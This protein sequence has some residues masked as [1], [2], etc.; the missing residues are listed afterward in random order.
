MSNLYAAVRFDGETDVIAFNNADE[1]RLFCEFHKE[2][3]F[4]PMGIFSLNEAMGLFSDDVI[5]PHCEHEDRLC[6]L[7]GEN[8]NDCPCCG[9]PV[10]VQN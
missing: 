2:Y 10:L 5:C 6:G 4:T 9:K 8:A 3:S 1:C 7:V